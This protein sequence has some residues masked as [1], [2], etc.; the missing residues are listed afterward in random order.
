[1][2]KFFES[3]AQLLGTIVSYI[4][5]FFVSLIT[6]IVRSVQAM[7]YVVVVIG[8]LPMYVK[9]FALAMIGVAAILFLI[10][11]GSD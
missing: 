9:V 4:V 3:I 2:F 5:D 6:V 11:K 10:N 8:Y 7:A 1:M